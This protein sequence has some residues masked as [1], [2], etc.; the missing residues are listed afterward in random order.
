MKNRF[1]AA[2]LTAAMIGGAAAAPAFAQA[3]QQQDPAMQQQPAAPD[4]ASITDEQIGSFVQ[5]TENINGVIE[6]YQPQVEQALAYDIHGLSYSNLFNLGCR[7]STC[8]VVLL[9]LIAIT[10]AIAFLSDPLNNLLAA[11][12]LFLLPAGIMYCCYV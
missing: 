2:A 9:V 8:S 6:E 5:A 1:L 12:L 10:A 3:A 11:G 4:P 7:V